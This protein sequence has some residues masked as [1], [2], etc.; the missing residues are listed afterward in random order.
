MNWLIFLV[1]KPDPTPPCK[2]DQVTEMTTIEN[3]R[4]IVDALCPI[5][6]EEDK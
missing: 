6:D 2:K 3:S 5:G 4:Q 1:R